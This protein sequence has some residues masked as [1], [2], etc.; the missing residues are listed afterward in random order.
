[1]DAP[2]VGY[3]VEAGVDL[4]LDLILVQVHLEADVHQAIVPCIVLP[5]WYC[6]QLKQT[7]FLKLCEIVDIDVQILRLK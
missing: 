1:M 6:L 4:P 3:Q 7:V 5:R 2:D